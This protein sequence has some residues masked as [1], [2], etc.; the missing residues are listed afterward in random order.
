VF[1]SSRRRFSPQPALVLEHVVAELV[2]EDVREHESSQ[3]RAGPCHDAVTIGG[4]ARGPQ[5][6]SFLRGEVEP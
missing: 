3:T 4:R 2:C 1:P 5:T 6:R